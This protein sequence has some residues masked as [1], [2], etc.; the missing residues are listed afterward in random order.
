MTTLDA[1][2]AA[3]TAAHGPRYTALLR[4]D[5][6]LAEHI[7]PLP[8]GWRRRR[9]TLARELREARLAYRTAWVEYRRLCE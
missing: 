2:L 7:G 5:V 3:A 1:L 4:A 8:T 9:A 6:A